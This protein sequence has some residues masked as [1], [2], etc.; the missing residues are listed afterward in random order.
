MPKK[1]IE[2]LIAKTDYKPLMVLIRGTM[3]A[4]NIEASSL[5]EFAGIS[6]DSLYRRFRM[7][8][9]FRLCELSGIARRLDIPWDE[10]QSRIPG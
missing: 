3:K 2:K 5:A 9:E 6:K 8:H 7:P 10:I 4:S 1:R